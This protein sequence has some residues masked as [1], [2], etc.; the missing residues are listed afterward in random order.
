MKFISC[1]VIVAL[2][3]LVVHKTEARYREPVVREF[4]ERVHGDQ[5]LDVFRASTE[6]TEAPIQHRVAI[7][8]NRDDEEVTYIALHIKYVRIMVYFTVAS[9]FVSRLT[10]Y[11]FSPLCGITVLVRN[12]LLESAQ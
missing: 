5:L 6:P 7:T 1:I 3:A 8:W 12:H 9:I 11:V 10:L 4:G 2:V